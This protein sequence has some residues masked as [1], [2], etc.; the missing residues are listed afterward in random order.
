M[1]DF[2]TVKATTTHLDSDT[3]QLI[4]ARAELNKALENLRDIVLSGN[5][6]NGVL[7]TNT[8]N[9]V[10][11][12]QLIGQVDSTS[13]KDESV[14]NDQLTDSCIGKDEIADDAIEFRHLNCVN[15]V[16][17][18]STT[19]LNTVTQARDYLKTLQPTLSGT[20]YVTS[21]FQVDV[22]TSSRTNAY[23]ISDVSTLGN[24]TNMVIVGVAF[25]HL[26]VTKDRY[27]NVS[28]HDTSSFDFWNDGSAS[29]YPNRIVF[30]QLYYQKIE[31]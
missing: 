4:N 6:A 10:N 27:N 13:L 16:V 30:F 24:G 12:F 22:T 19:K 17:D 7:V 1:T 15:T 21:L 8:N 23:G 29:K 28:S 3:D 18:T 20:I 31:V 14:T 9:K 5:D 11:L 2:P 25:K 26:G